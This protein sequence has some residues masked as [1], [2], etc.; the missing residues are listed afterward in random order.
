MILQFQPYNFQKND[1]IH[2]TSKPNKDHY[3]NYHDNTNSN[4]YSKPIYESTKPI[5][6][7]VYTSSKDLSSQR[8]NDVYRNDTQKKI[9]FDEKFDNLSKI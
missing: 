1:A 6:K 2:E 5:I 4:E 3:E 7:D 9:E 8:Q